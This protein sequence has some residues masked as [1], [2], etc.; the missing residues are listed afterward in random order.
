MTSDMRDQ[1]VIFC[2]KAMHCLFRSVY[3]ECL[4]V[5]LFV[6]IAESYYIARLTSS[7]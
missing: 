5:C 1:K 3:L 2:K 6:L 4:F 7:L